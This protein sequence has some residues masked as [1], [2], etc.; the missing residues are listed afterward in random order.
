MTGSMNNTVV[1]S[2]EHFIQIKRQVFS[3]DHK[4]FSSFNLVTF[5]E[6]LF[7]KS[8]QLTSIHN[9]FP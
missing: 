2:K 6:V 7:T 3:V 4:S 8:K 9:V 1:L 5:S